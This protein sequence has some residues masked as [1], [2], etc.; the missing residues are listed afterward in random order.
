[1]QSAVLLKDVEISELRSELQAKAALD[2][3]ASLGLAPKLEALT[4]EGE[5]L[6]MLLR[7][8]QA[9]LER[10]KEEAQS[11]GT[12]HLR[13]VDEHE[14][15]RHHTL[16]TQHQH[17]ILTAERDSLASRIT[18]LQAQLQA[19]EHSAAASCESLSASRSELAAKEATLIESESEVRQLELQLERQIEKLEA[20]TLENHALNDEN[21]FMRNE[22]EMYAK[23]SKL[24]KNEISLLQ[25]SHMMRMNRTGLMV[26]VVFVTRARMWKQEDCN[27]NS[28]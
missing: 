9:E 25:A 27:I 10:A 15:L 19:S 17:E 12:R 23:E 4:E 1:M 5:R 2:R 22:L 3:R 20:M 18:N 6:K 13:L 26:H 28:L 16:S 8:K 24:L 11:L 14:Q 7:E 21:H